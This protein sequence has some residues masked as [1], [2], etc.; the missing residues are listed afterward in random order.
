MEYA[1]QSI[2]TQKPII[3]IWMIMMKI[4][5]HHILLGV[6]NFYGWAMSQ[7]LPTFNFEW[8]EDTSYFNEHFIK[9]YGE[10]YF[11]EVHVQYPKKLCELPN[12]LPFLAERKNLGK[13]EKLV[14]W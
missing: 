2:N 10:G 13:V 11:L 12:D 1:I 7:R 5:N 3:N 6:N 8:V 4:K 9:N 14:T